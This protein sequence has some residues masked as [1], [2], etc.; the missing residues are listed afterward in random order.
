MTNTISKTVSDE[1]LDCIIQIESAGNPKAKAPTSSALGLFQFLNKTW[2][3]TV[4]AHRP[5][6]F[7]ETP[8]EKLLAMRT[9]PVFCIEM[10]ARFTEDNQRAIGMNCTGGDLYLAHFLGTGDAKDFYHADSS[11]PADKLVS[12][13]VIAANRSIFIVN[14]EMQNAGQIRAWAARKMAKAGGRGWIKKYCPQVAPVPQAEET[15]ENIPDP[16]DAPTVVV[17]ADAPPV[18][19]EKRSEESAARDAE[20]SGSWLKRKWKS[21]TGS[22]GGLLGTAGV[23]IFDWRIVALLLAFIVVVSLFMIWFMGPGSVREWI[24]KQVA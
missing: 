6:V 22:I 5:D 21:V 10:G 18:V 1:T 3:G 9:E 23:G 20:P 17:P 13:Q 16:Q 11:T 2:L 24:R 14:G 19:V 12:A 4:K 8:T 15:A 7:T